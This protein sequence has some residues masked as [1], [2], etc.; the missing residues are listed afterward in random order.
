MPTSM[1]SWKQKRRPLELPMALDIYKTIYNKACVAGGIYSLVLAILYFLFN[2][3]P[4]L[5]INFLIASL[6]FIL[7]HLL[8]RKQTHSFLKIKLLFFTIS[9]GV[10]IADFFQNGG[11]YSP[12]LF[13]LVPVSIMML[14]LTSKKIRQ[15]LSISLVLLLVLFFSIQYYYPSAIITNDQNILLIERIISLIIS[16]FFSTYLITTILE[17][18]ILEKNRALESE[19]LKGKF[20]ATMSHMI[21]T[22]LNSINGF[23]DFLIDNDVSETEKKFY[24]K[25]ISENAQNL[26]LLINNL[27]RLSIIQNNS[28]KLNHTEFSLTEFIE[29]LE[30]MAHD[31]I[32]KSGRNIHFIANKPSDNQHIQLFTD[33]RLLSEALWNIIQNAIRFTAKG[34]VQMNISYMDKLKGLHIEIID[35]G[36]GI[37]EEQLKQLFVLMNKQRDSF[38]RE[39]DKSPGLGLNISQGIIKA[40]HGKIKVHSTYKKGSTVSIDIPKCILQ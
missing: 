27:V 28:L 6:S 12:S 13:L 21:R 15:R 32:A 16:L 23:A 34:S 10:I 11:I 24:Q 31:L 8:I 3:S 25:R 17:Q 1:K 30:S 39:D 18:H 2:A 7:V 4:Y 20:L 14:I 5:G 9:F 19:E 36:I 29:N 35:T 26:S 40:L 33:N 38:S 22:P 37:K